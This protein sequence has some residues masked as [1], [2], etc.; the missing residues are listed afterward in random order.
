MR[1]GTG[2]R[3][4]KKLVEKK[5]LAAPLVNVFARWTFMAKQNT[6]LY[7]NRKVTFWRREG[8]TAGGA[9]GR[10]GARDPG[11]ERR[12]EGVAAGGNAG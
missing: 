7:E 4:K 6:I 3:M 10:A 11:R 2:A 9:G 1:T 5:K 12:R 8:D